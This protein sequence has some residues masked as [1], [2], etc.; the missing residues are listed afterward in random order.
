M[1]GITVYKNSQPIKLT[2]KNFLTS[3]GEGSIYLKDNLIYKIY[4]A[5]I[6]VSYLEKF[7]E[8][9]V[10]SDSHILKPIDILYND[11]QYPIGFTMTY[12]SDTEAVAKMFVTS[13]RNRN[14][15]TNDTISQF[16]EN[17]AKTLQSIHSHNTLVVDLNELN[18]L[19]KKGQYQVPLFIDVDSFQTPSFPA[20]AIM[21][22]IKDYLAKSF[23]P[24][25]DWYSYAVIGFQLY[26]G[27]HPYK[28]NHSKYKQNDIASRA[29]DCISVFNKDVRYPTQ[30]VRSFDD[31]PSGLKDWF[32]RLFEKGE[33]LPIP[34]QF[35]SIGKAIETIVVGSS[36]VQIT[37]D[38]AHDEPIMYIS[39]TRPILKSMANR[40]QWVTI[41]GIDYILNL[42]NGILT[43]TNNQTGEVTHTT[44]GGKKLIVT[45][46]NQI[47]LLTEEKLMHIVFMNLGIKI[48]VGI[49]NAWDIL[50]IATKVYKNILIS[51]VLGRTY[52][53]VPRWST[54]HIFPVKDLDDCKILDAEY[55]NE[56]VT[57]IG[58]KNGKYN[59]YLIRTHPDDTYQIQVF[60]DISPT[61]TN[62]CVLPNGI[63]VTLTADD[64]I[65]ITTKTDEKTKTLTNVGIHKGARLFNEGVHVKYFIGNEVYSIKMK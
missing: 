65:Q 52:F 1:S 5:P 2:E 64:E 27:I 24:L 21:P 42:R 57:V 35:G 32:Y 30:A 33:R 56:V 23:S 59:R 31:I 12:A 20:S 39:G 10:L 38:H 63:V 14:S 16:M 50:P 6:P 43:C 60:E 49:D 58:F 19:A 9:S 55:Q 62:F 7:K 34:T 11:K 17:G 4:L 40:G 26:T 45:D 25:T 44:I 28:G 8:L 41:D 47:Y 54:C 13:F 22:S 18:L 3:G 36:L 51:N 15:I 46:D 37:I 29:K 61:E 53:F 48:V